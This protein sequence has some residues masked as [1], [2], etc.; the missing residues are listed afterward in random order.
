MG[1]WPQAC[2]LSLPY[3]GE[4]VSQSKSGKE[5]ARPAWEPISVLPL[6]TCVTT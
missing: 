4:A 6:T 5:R 1:L 2:S 3:K